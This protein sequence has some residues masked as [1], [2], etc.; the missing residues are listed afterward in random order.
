[1]KSLREYGWGI[2]GGL[3][4]SL[5]LLYTMEVCWAA[6][7]RAPDSCCSAGSSCTSSTSRGR[8]ASPGGGCSETW[9]SEPA[10]AELDVLSLG[11]SDP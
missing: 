5:S 3:L 7:S 6:S 2:A 11:Y 1:M 9:A 10:A 4:F 8:S